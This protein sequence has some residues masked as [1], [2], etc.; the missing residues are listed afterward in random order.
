MMVN[1]GQR[2]LNFWRRWKAAVLREVYKGNI[3]MATLTELQDVI[4]NLF[5]NPTT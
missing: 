2:R 4:Q 5:F 3:H 1:E